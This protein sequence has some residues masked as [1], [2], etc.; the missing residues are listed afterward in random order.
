MN[1]QSIREALEFAPKEP[2][3]APPPMLR[4]W[5]LPGDGGLYYVCSHCAGRMVARGCSLGKAEPV[6][7]D[8]PDPYGQCCGCRV[9]PS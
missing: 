5:W 1:A 9:K 3:T 7:K 4:G 2:S 6:W 8:R